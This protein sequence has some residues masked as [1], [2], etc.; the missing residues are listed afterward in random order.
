MTR[1]MNAIL[2]HVEQ[3]SEVDTGDVS[4][5]SF[6]EGKATP[7][8]PDEVKSFGNRDEALANAPKSEGTF[9][10]VPKVIE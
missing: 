7:M 4:P 9:Y 8:K 2:E 3:L 1:D 10:I 5:H 6:L